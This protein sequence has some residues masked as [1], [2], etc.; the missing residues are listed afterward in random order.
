MI[1]DMIMY[2]ATGDNEK[3]EYMM[4]KFT[5]A[6]IVAALCLLAL[7]AASWAIGIEA[8]V[9]IWG[10]TPSGDVQY[11]ETSDK[12]DLVDDLGFEDEKKMMGRVKVDMPALIP[13]VYL[14]GTK[15]DYE[16]KS[17]RPFTFGDTPFLV[18]STTTLVMDHYDL[19]LYYG[20]PFLETL[21]ADMLNIELGLNARMVDIEAK[22]EAPILGLKESKSI[23]MVIPMIYAGVQIR[24]TDKLAFELE[25]R[26]MSYSGNSFYDWIARL[27]VKPLGPIFIAAG[28]RYESIKIEEDDD[29]ADLVFEGPFAEAGFQF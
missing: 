10:Q 16:G 29:K 8:A 19:A 5:L 1:R 6:A 3:E 26:G 24:P 17:K 23:S 7:P 11:K 22:V 28:Y 13:N 18:N 20:L 9:G 14:M 15:M 4:R 12:V 25:G 2:H 27:K 21:S